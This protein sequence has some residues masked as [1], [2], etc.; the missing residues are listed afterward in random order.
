LITVVV[1]LVF[2]K[3]WEYRHDR[4]G[5]WRQSARSDDV[6]ARIAMAYAPAEGTV[7]AASPK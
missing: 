3:A 7:R 1:G 2:H 4:D 5:K 6:M